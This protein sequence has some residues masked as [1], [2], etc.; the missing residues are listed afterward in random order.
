MRKRFI[1]AVLFGL[2]ALP[3]ALIA[4]LAAFA[5]AYGFAWL[6]VF[7]DDPWPATLGAPLILL[8]ACTFVTI[9]VGAIA[10]GFVIG[11]R[12]EG[13]RCLPFGHLL[14]SLAATLVPLLVI[15]AH[16]YQVGNLG[17]QSDSLLCQDYC[18]ASGFS[19]SGLPPRDTGERRCIC[20]ADNGNEALTAPIAEIAQR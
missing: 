13:D 6:F 19:M 3:L 8:F 1:Y 9:W 5:A 20:Y 17:P 11:K 7:G 4:A 10:A 16:Q 2:P 14:T 12:F 18:V 15:V